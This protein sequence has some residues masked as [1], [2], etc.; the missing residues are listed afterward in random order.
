M[1]AK[2]KIKISDDMEL[3][4]V[5]DD[6]YENSSQIKLCRYA[7]LLA[8]HILKTIDYH[9][10]DSLAIKAGFA[11][12]E[13]W[14]KGNARMHHV[15]QAGFQIH[16]LAK[17][18]QDMVIRMAL[19]AVGQAVAAGHMREHAMVSSDYAVR[20]INLLF[21]NDLAAVRRERMWQIE[22]LKSIEEPAIP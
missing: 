7:L 20:V 1:A 4:K 5:L 8:E 14:Q 10:A 17:S 3:R 2:T 6:E 13:S 15:R 12:N 19:R 11:V 22:C 9:D 16:R 18:S 21:P